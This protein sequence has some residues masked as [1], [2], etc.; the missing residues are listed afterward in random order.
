MVVASIGD[1]KEIFSENYNELYLPDNHK[2]LASMVL[3]QIEEPHPTNV[4]IE[5]WE[6]Q[7]QKLVLAYRS[8][9][10]FMP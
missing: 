1:M 6:A 9:I 7:A 2:H 8:H 4:S 10:E 5:N 3:K